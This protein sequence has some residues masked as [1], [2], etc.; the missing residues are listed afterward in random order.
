MQARKILQAATLVITVLVTGWLL[1]DDEGGERGRALA[2]VSNAKWQA[3]CSSCH[4][5]YHPG[6]LPERSWRRMMSDLDKHFNEN[7]SL[8]P[9]TQKEITEFLVRNSADHAASRRSS[10]ISQSIPAAAAPLRITETAWFIRKHDEVNPA[11]WKR[12]RIGSASNCIACHQ[13]AE[14]GNFPEEGVRIPR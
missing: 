6:L 4:M 7:A 11:V 13:G 8:D 2:P 5:L 3:E 9:L 12:A 14:K 10:R 1:A